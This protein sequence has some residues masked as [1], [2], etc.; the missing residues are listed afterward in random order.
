MRESFVSY[1]AEMH[2]TLVP[3]KQSRQVKTMNAPAEGEP[4]SLKQI[5]LG[6]GTAASTSEALRASFNG[7]NA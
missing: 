3:H 5:Y 6:T 4:E 2:A 1:V 7:K